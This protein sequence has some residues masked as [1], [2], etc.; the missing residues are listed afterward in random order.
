MSIQG[1][2][3]RESARVE[4]IASR[5][6]RLRLNPTT[7]D[8]DA[9]ADADE[10]AFIEPATSF[11]DDVWTHMQTPNAQRGAVLPWTKT[12]HDIQVRPGE[13][14][15]WSGKRGQGKSLLL[16]QIML[17]LMRQGQRAVIASMEMPI[18]ATLE[19]MERQALGLPQPSREYHDA[20]YDW[21]Q[22][23]L[24]LYTQRDEVTAR[25]VIGLC[26]YARQE[27]R[28]D[29]VVIDSLMMVRMPG[30]NQFARLDSQ[31]A[32]VR[33]LSALAR[34]SGLHVHLVAH[35]R[36]SSGSDKDGDADEVKGAGEITDLA[37]NVYFVA[38]N[39]DK[40]AEAGKEESTRKASIMAQPDAFLSVEK[41][42]DGGYHGTVGLWLHE[43]SLQFLGNDTGRAMVMLQEAIGF[44]RPADDG[45]DAALDAPL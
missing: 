22:D 43:P 40:R 19:R 3:K 23:R 26:R 32:F 6:D 14:S 34:D 39:R 41:V 44:S 35:R 42:R 5:I 11:R 1:Q 28:V 24:W 8:F 21:Y 30:A 27:L 17:A 45:I 10:S 36:K 37:S 31:G 13:L 16:G 9:Y 18:I 25:R 38:A 33:K 12:H 20:L 4:S 2:A 7:I 15:I 29:H